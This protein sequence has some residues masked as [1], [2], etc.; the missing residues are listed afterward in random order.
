MVSVRV[1]PCSSVANIEKICDFLLE[2]SVRDNIK[3]DD[4]EEMRILFHKLSEQKERLKICQ[5]EKNLHPLPQTIK[6]IKKI[7]NRIEKFTPR[8]KSLKDFI[9]LIEL[10]ISDIKS[11]LAPVKIINTRR[12]IT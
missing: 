3:P 4:R 7:N 8:N 10:L 1:V 9:P 12:K 5:K 6:T 11:L 2:L